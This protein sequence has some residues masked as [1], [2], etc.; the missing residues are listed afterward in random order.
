VSTVPKHVA[1]YTDDPEFGGVAHYNH[2]VLLA[3]AAQG[4]RVTCIQGFSN[5]PLVKEQQAAGIK[6]EWIGYDAKKDFPR[7]ITDV[8]DAERIIRRVNPDLLFFSD[9]CPVSNLAAKHVAVQRNLPFIVVVHFAAPYLA[10]NFA[11]CLGVMAK[12][13]AR[14]SALVAVSHEN[15]ALLER[16]FGS[17]VGKGIVI[18]NGRP[19]NYFEPVSP[20]SR[21]RLRKELGI[22]A[23]GVMCFS[24]ARLTEVKG[25]QY[26]AA[27]AA[28]LKQTAVA[29]TLYY[30][31]AGDGD[32][33]TQLNA[34]IAQYQLGNQFR[35]LGQ[36]WDVCD[37]YGASDIFVLPSQFEGMP[38]TIMEAM[39][40]RVPVIAS[41]V[42]G[43]PEEV[44]DAGY[45]VPDPMTDVEGTVR[46]LATGLMT[47]AADPKLRKAA[48][49]SGHARAEKLF[50]EELM[51]SR[52]TGLVG[53]T[54]AAAAESRSMSVARFAV[55]RPKSPISNLLAHQLEHA[56]SNGDGSGLGVSS[57][58]ADGTSSR[59]L[60]MDKLES[61]FAKVVPC[62]S[63]PVADY[64]VRSPV[65]M[66]VFNRPTH[67]A[68]VFAAVRR[69][70]PAQLLL[71][72]DGPRP[73]RPN[74][75]PLCAEVRSIVSQI[76]WPCEVKTDFS[77]ANQGPTKRIV[78][79]LTWVFEQ[80]ERC[81]ILEDD[82]L[83]SPDF[84]RFCDAMLERYADDE[85]VRCV[86]GNNFQFGLQRGDGSY[87]FTPN[88]LIWGWA[89][90]RRAW[91]NYDVAMKQWP[92]LR[93]TKFLQEKLGDQKAVGYWSN[94]FDAA[95]AGR[96]AWDFPWT[97]SCWTNGGIGISPEVELIQN[98][99]CDT[100]ATGNFSRVHPAFI[101]L[102]ALMPVGRL[103]AELKAPS[104]SGPNLAAAA[105]N[106]RFH[107]EHNF[108]LL[109]R[110]LASIFV[111]MTDEKFASYLSHSSF[112]TA[113]NLARSSLAT[114]PIIEEDKAILQRL[115]EALS[116]PNARPQDLL[117]AALYAG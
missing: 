44:G 65:C 110:E 34:Q 26:I 83:P 81:I 53:E 42:S 82:C 52:V 14:A 70:R 73:A 87:F 105:F 38:L 88:I 36:R 40:R 117:A 76:D 46:G 89:T 95:H 111:A 97:F 61:A 11:K 90:W 116:K 75:A 66:L 104:D 77:E 37:L 56:S 20:E 102:F 49:D 55:E 112:A 86:S 78:S 62:D 67:T 58:P 30:V 113:A 72:A 79:G 84:F 114:I 64:S 51:L 33:K 5:S 94:A 63:A 8:V 15:L 115:K 60:L 103:D 69:A 21:A 39:A 16:R 54:L 7:S 18:H 96:T 100:Q 9:C 91:R 41:A 45:L 47:W 23:N 93:A 32:F 85:K 68:R 92:A 12:Q 48:A 25:F 107:Y 24:A 109:R 108:P 106:Q 10:E 80:V 22:P 31:W 35:L 98:I 71:V 19:K 59:S 43:I 13:H 3:L 1:I 4:Y 27:A 99:G 29:K 2:N 17:P 28:V 74:D 101:E 6:H 50:R 57:H